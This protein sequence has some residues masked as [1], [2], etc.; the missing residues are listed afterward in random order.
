MPLILLIT[1][2]HQLVSNSSSRGFSWATDQ[3][4]SGVKWSI[5]NYR[6]KKSSSNN[7]GDYMVRDNSQIRG[8]NLPSQWLMLYSVANT[9]AKL[10]NWA[11]FDYCVAGKKLS[12][13]L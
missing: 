11:T 10:R 12:L 6:N 1:H 9:T 3:G 5:G 8:I 7:V 13:S 4:L 2:H